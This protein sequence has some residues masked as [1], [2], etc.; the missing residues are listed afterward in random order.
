MNILLAMDTSSASQ[1]ALEQVAARDVER[2]LAQL[3]TLSTSATARP[4]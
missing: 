1:A 2:P 3:Q 4:R